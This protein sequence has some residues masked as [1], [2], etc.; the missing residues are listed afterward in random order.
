M[1]FLKNH[2]ITVAVVS[3]THIGSTVSLCPPKIQLDDGQIVEPSPPQR[4]L[5]QNWNDFWS[6]AKGLGNKEIYTFLLGDVFDNKHHGTTQLWSENEA[7]WKKAALGIFET[8]KH[9]SK[10][11]FCIRGTIVHTKAGGSLD[12]EMAIMLNAVP[13]SLGNKSSWTRKVYVEDVLFDLAHKGPIGQL[14]WT[15]GNALNRLP[16]EIVAKC[17]KENSEIPK[18]LIRSHNHMYGTSGDDSPIFTVSAPAWQLC[19]EY[20]YNLNPARISDIGGLLFECWD[21]KYE[22][23]KVLYKPE[24]EKPWRG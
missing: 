10:H 6:Q 5:W 1:P 16:Y 19:T 21:G 20:G 4:W 3:D 17:I 22:F 11:I 13:D 8:P 23:H 24:V 9:L 12:E 2:R 14:P 18:V 7:D 15:R